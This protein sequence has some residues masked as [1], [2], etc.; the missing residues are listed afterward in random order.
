MINRLKN[1]RYFDQGHVSV[2]S[3]KQ[4]QY[5]LNWRIGV[6]RVGACHQRRIMLRSKEHVL[7]QRLPLQSNN[8][9]FMVSWDSVQMAV[10]VSYEKCGFQAFLP[11]FCRRQ[12]DAIF[13]VR[14]ELKYSFHAS[15]APNKAEETV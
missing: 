8:R 5:D 14:D 6:P 9:R 1:A 4:L 2:F 10:I 11:S 15:I 7:F 12:Q 3:V 13:R